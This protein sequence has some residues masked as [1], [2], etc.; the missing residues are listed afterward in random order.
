MVLGGLELPTLLGCINPKECMKK[1]ITIS[2][3]LG[4]LKTMTKRH[5]E[6]VV[7][8]N[9]NAAVV[10]ANYQG[11]VIKKVPQYDVK[12][13]DKLVAVLSREIRLCEA[14]IKSTNAK[15][16]VIDYKADD[17]VLAELT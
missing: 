8:R 13:L 5:G 7:L 17:D 1:D 15:T 2:E 10:E 9:A 12:A 11:Q 3:A 16:V 4:W 6:L 14:A